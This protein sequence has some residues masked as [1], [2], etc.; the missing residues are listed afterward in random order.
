ML[1]I[2]LFQNPPCE[3]KRKLNNFEKGRIISFLFQSHLVEKFPTTLWNPFSCVVCFIVHF[4]I[5]DFTWISRGFVLIHVLLR[6]FEIPQIL[7][8]INID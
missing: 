8:L 1:H 6:V 3:L 2:F 5:H 7:I 4:V